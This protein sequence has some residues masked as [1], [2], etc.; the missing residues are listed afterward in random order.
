[1]TIGDLKKRIDVQAQT[2]TPDGAGGF[3]ISWVTIASQIA[4]AIWPVSANEQIQ[5]QAVTMIVTHRIRIRYRHILKSGWRVSWAGKYFNIVS[6]VD[7][8]MQHKWLDLMCKE[9]AG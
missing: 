9:A 8:S 3:T 5:A 6:V 1:M 2:R 4:A 7:V